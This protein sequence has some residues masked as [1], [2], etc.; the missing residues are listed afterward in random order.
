LQN[1][2]HW[3]QGLMENQLFPNTIPEISDKKE[4][5]A[6]LRKKAGRPTVR[7]EVNAIVNGV[8]SSFAEFDIVKGKA[9]IQL[10]NFIHDYLVAM[11]LIKPDDPYVT[12]TWIKSQISNFQKPGKDPKFFTTEIRPCSLDDLKNSDLHIRGLNWL[13]PPKVSAMEPKQP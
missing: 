9:P 12:T 1:D 2:F 3:F 10:L 4:A 7:K 5:K 11:D 13:L 6:M 8:A